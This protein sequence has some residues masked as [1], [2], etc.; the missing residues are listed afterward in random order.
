[1]LLKKFNQINRK[2]PINMKTNEEIKALVKEKYTEIAVQDK[3][4]N[5]SS[6][7]GCGPSCDSTYTIMSED[8]SSLKGYSADA[9][10]ALGCGIPTSIAKISEGNTVVDLGS[11]AGN[12]CFV[13]RAIV[14]EKGRVVG[15][16]MTPAMIDKARE[17]AEKLGFNNVEFRLGEIEK[18]P[19]SANQADVVLSNCVLNL[20]P[21][22]KKAFA[23]MFR[24]TKPGGHFSISDI[25]LEGHL[26]EGI[27]K[28]GELYAGCVSGAIPRTDYL[29]QLAE[30]GFKNVRVE[31]E[32][33]IEIPDEILLH[34]I[35]AEEISAFRRSG[36]GIT[37]ITV[38]G[39][40][41][42]ACCGPNCCN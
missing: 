23:E 30:A 26:P 19:M 22:K 1:V 8:Y 40:K 39:E 20:V 21:D 25:V 12:D 2:K 7:C 41:P 27:R 3:S 35:S 31:K 14:G 34:Y 29:V 15:I 37:S 10:L 11:G 13:A 17:N 6:C 42:E 4:V 36:T 33:K 9:D 5:A 38:Y 32:K 16:D 18:I 28:A 24:I